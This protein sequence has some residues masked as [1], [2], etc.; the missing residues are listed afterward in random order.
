MWGGHDSVLSMLPAIHINSAPI[1]KMKS[2]LLIF[3]I[4]LTINL[5]A[6]KAEVDLTKNFLFKDGLYLTYESFKNNQPDLLWEE[7]KASLHTNPQTLITQVFSIKKDQEE[8]S[9]NKL[10]GFCIDGLPFVRIEPKDSLSTIVEYAALTWRGKICYFSFERNEEKE[11]EMSA[12]NPLTRKAFR[13]TTI[14]RKVK[15]WEEKMLRFDDGAIEDFTINNFKTW[16]ADDPDLLFTL[17]KM[18]KEKAEEELFQFLI[19]Y[20]DRNVVFIKE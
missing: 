13:T 9:K 19:D 10:W 12:Y 20:S 4:C 5:P 2:I 18:D 3:S 11:I 1:S 17:N 8:L 16:I 7:T 14:K 15:H 6:Q